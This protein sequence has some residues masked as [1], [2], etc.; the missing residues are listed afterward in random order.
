MFLFRFSTGHGLSEEMNTLFRFWCYFMR[1]HFNE[2]MHKQFVKLAWE[3]AEHNYNYGLEC[4]FRQEEL[5]YGADSISSHWLSSI[6]PSQS[7]FLSQQPY[8]GLKDWKS[9]MEV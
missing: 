5:A 1:D 8:N 9:L 6:M 2:N 4:L 7:W 3:D